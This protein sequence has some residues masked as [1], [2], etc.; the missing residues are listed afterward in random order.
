[1]SDE[2]NIPLDA[3][4][5][6]TRE[7]MLVP[8]D[9]ATFH[10]NDQVV[11]GGLMSNTL[12]YENE[13]YVAGHYLYN[14][15]SNLIGDV[16]TNY[17]D[18]VVRKVKDVVMLCDKQK[19]TILA[20]F[21]YNNI[22]RI[23]VGRLDS[24]VRIGNRY[25]IKGITNRKDAFTIT[26]NAYTLNIVSVDGIDKTKYNINIQKQNMF[27]SISIEHII[28]NNSSIQYVRPVIEL[29]NLLSIK[30][31]TIENE[32]WSYNKQ[33][34]KVVNG[35]VSGEI[36]PQSAITKQDKDGQQINLQVQNIADISVD[37]KAQ[38]EGKI[39][40]ETRAIDICHN[41]ISEEQNKELAAEDKLKIRIISKKLGTVPNII[42][43]E[44]YLD[45]SNPIR[46]GLT[47]DKTMYAGHVNYDL[48]SGN[49][50]EYEDISK[51]LIRPDLS[52]AVQ[53]KLHKVNSFGRLSL[54]LINK[55]SGTI[56]SIINPAHNID[57]SVTYDIRV[58]VST[59]QLYPTM[60]NVNYTNIQDVA[61]SLW[62][63]A[64]GYSSHREVI[65]AVIT[66]LSNT[67]YSYSMDNM[68]YQKMN[69][70]IGIKGIRMPKNIS[71]YLEYDAGIGAYK[72]K[73]D[74]ISKYPTL[75]D[76]VKIR[77]GKGKTTYS[78]NGT[79]SV[80]ICIKSRNES[81]SDLIVV[82]CDL[83]MSTYSTQIVIYAVTLL[84]VNAAT[85][86]AE[87]N[88]NNGQLNI[89]VNI[90]RSL[91]VATRYKIAVTSWQ[92]KEY[93]CEEVNTPGY[94]PVEDV[95]DYT[96]I[97][98]KLELDKNGYG[99]CSFV[100]S[101]NNYDTQLYIRFIGRTMLLL[102]IKDKP[103]IIDAN[104]HK[105]KH[106]T[107]IS[108][109]QQINGQYVQT[110]TQYL[111]DVCNK[112]YIDCVTCK[113]C[114]WDINEATY[115]IKID[116]FKI[117]QSQAYI[118]LKLTDKHIYKGYIRLPHIYG[119]GVCSDVRLERVE[120]DSLV[121]QS[122]TLGN[123]TIVGDE[124]HG[125]EYYIVLRQ[126][127]GGKIYM[128]IGYNNRF[129]GLIGF[130][131]MIYKKS[132][133]PEH[134]EAL[135]NEYYF[136]D[137]YIKLA[138]DTRTKLK[139]RAEDIRK[140]RGQA[141]IDI[142]DAAESMCL[143]EVLNFNR[144]PNIG[145][146]IK[147]DKLDLLHHYYVL[148]ST[149]ALEISGE[150]VRLIDMPIHTIIAQAKTSDLFPY[151]TLI[152]IGVT[153]T[154]DSIPMIYGIC[155]DAKDSHKFYIY[156]KSVR[157][158][159][160][161][162]ADWNVYTGA[163]T[164][165][166]NGLRYFGP[167][168][169]ALQVLQTSTISAITTKAPG[170][171]TFVIGIKYQ[172]G[173][174]QWT[175]VGDRVVQGFG[176][177]G[178]NNLITGNWVPTQ[179]CS[180]DGFNAS[181]ITAPLDLDKEGC[182]DNNGEILFNYSAT[183]GYVYALLVTGTLITQ[184]E[185]SSQ[186]RY[187]HVQ[188]KQEIEWDV[189]PYYGTIPIGS[190]LVQVLEAA[191]SMPITLLYA[192]LFAGL[193]KIIRP[194]PPRI[195]LP[196]D[197]GSFLDLD[198]L[199][200]HMIFNGVNG[201]TG[202]WFYGNTWLTSARDGKLIKRDE[203]MCQAS[204]K[205][206][207]S[208]AATE[209][210]RALSDVMMSALHNKAKSRIV[211]KEGEEGREATFT[212]AQERAMEAHIASGPV[213]SHGSKD[214][215]EKAESLGITNTELIASIESATLNSVGSNKTWRQRLQEL[216][217]EGEPG[218]PTQTLSERTGIAPGIAVKQAAKKHIVPLMNSIIESISN[219]SEMHVSVNNELYINDDII[220][221]CSPNQEVYSGPGYY[222]IQL[223]R[224]NRR[225]EDYQQ[226]A[227]WNASGA[228]LNLFGFLSGLQFSILGCGLTMPQ[229]PVVIPRIYGTG[230]YTKSKKNTVEW[231]G[232]Q[233]VYLN[234]PGTVEHSVAFIE[235]GTNLNIVDE[236]KEWRP[237]DTPMQ[238]KD[239]EWQDIRKDVHITHTGGTIIGNVNGLED[240]GIAYTDSPT[241][242]T[243]M[244]YDALILPEWQLYCTYIGDS[245]VHLSIDD[246]K[247]VDGTYT[248][249]VSCDDGLYIATTYNITQVIQ[250]VEQN[251][252]K[253]R[254]ILGGLILNKTGLNYI[255][256]LNIMHA[257]DGYANRIKCWK[258]ESGGDIEELC[259]FSQYLPF[260]EN[261]PIHSMFPP[262]G[263]MGKFNSVPTIDY[264]YP[265][266]F[267]TK[268][269]QCIQPYTNIDIRI[270]RISIPIFFNRVA[271][272]PAGVQTVGA[273]KLFVVDGV[274]SLTTDSRS[275]YIRAVSDDYDVMIYGKVFRA[276]EEYLSLV[277]QQYGVLAFRDVALKVGQKVIGSD[278]KNIL[279]YS[280]VTRQLYLFTGDETLS[281]QFTAY[282]ITDVD[283]A[284]YEF[285]RQ[286]LIARACLLNKKQPIALLRF[287]A[288][289]PR[290]MVPL[291]E[292]PIIDT[293]GGEI[294]YVMQ[295]DERAQ[296][297]FNIYN[298]D[299]L[300]LNIKGNRGKWQKIKGDS[301]DDF[302]SKRIYAERPEGYFWEPFRLATSFVGI[303]DDTDCL[304]EWV[305]TFA[306]TTWMH[307]IIEDRY[308]TV[309]IA[310]ETACPNGHRRSEVTKL[311]LR[312]D[313]FQ[314][315]EEQI[316]YYSF[317]FNGRNG[318]GNA[319]RL[320][321]WSDGLIAIRKIIVSVKQV[322]NA[323]TSPALTQADFVAVEEL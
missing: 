24:C 77:W 300:T 11:E 229:L 292:L 266:N 310:S 27:M 254:T 187:V 213:G 157:F 108:K 211:R 71:I 170:Q 94:V 299:M 163:F 303:N 318:A 316:G 152:R 286:E 133:I 186:M 54:Q 126:V 217:D 89:S 164:R 311:R 102:S 259:S 68:Q 172:R 34:I 39:I 115:G 245:V 196:R 278:T 312:N 123:F 228:I 167:E 41:L 21:T 84:R 93:S 8:V 279:L 91:N 277:N 209:L 58:V 294:G 207:I 72:I 322:T 262:S 190:A 146:N 271:D 85:H 87:F 112:Y 235:P 1:M 70:D 218:K 249:I 125:T 174:N 33:K 309:F 2:Y 188:D 9:K 145:S 246:T 323:R 238:V 298:E 117:K 99:V 244:I 113:I 74:I 103:S 22:N 43:F 179:C 206:N 155:Y 76:V 23:T 260:K 114:K 247:I 118:K 48:M 265:V 127:I 216:V 274:T 137:Y 88:N 161:Q 267:V 36:F 69:D 252:I 182:Y 26:I 204:I 273:Y 159:D 251:D 287:D 317:R 234:G 272:Y 237:N 233:H 98:D 320:F 203:S 181:I 86:K 283:K 17:P 63:E 162:Y 241:F 105:I 149:R 111:D 12:K 120:G 6:L 52:L 239:W 231:Y 95:V 250:G 307:N 37:I 202:S 230:N 25:I 142:P 166:L 236:S 100:D 50:E 18:A 208:D 109:I 106:T 305:I 61:G 19:G 189:V 62:H 199:P 81:S 65:D 308:V 184:A 200:G 73:C 20:K 135:P 110:I 64:W 263:I 28:P 119:T 53:C 180:R 160:L 49:A 224:S 141:D 248:N 177:V 35:V 282:R 55:I 173:M 150:H 116:S 253:P 205:Y 256:K 192:V 121:C 153:S 215:R 96:L 276:F 197:L 255:S 302:F 304:F 80:K 221:T 136:G 148:S 242:T 15:E 107:S 5:E 51:K 240:D 227:T 210:I 219:E 92:D 193:P 285:L 60:L 158:N 30:D 201:Y 45:L 140:N 222:S 270:I 67:G 132:N 212:A 3:N 59:I 296:V 306:Y 46:I 66:Y 258:G 130:I 289:Q 144:E 75:Q 16:E 42:E 313:M 104:M 143:N 31:I 178:I 47:G 79:Y 176:S 154:I 13:G 183:V 56:E 83:A 226:M 232:G 288:L 14:I 225:L 4:L 32:D 78:A 124:L 195:R 194:R 297:V 122:D 10:F 321:I 301:I 220:P 295:S 29:A 275:G 101:Y 82:T 264:K 243:P 57:I 171:N 269:V 165:T 175:I 290:G 293:F 261:I 90:P 268:D 191:I 319:E 315:T 214:I 138:A 169:T 97:S 314:R 147:D 38:V 129:N 139:V 280:K 134:K 156:Y 128:L 168:L 7:D 40:Y 291:F 223:V 198:I 281:K 284:V 44:R 257:F 131:G 151:T 185:L